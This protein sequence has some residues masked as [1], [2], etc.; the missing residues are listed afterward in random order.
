MTAKK[1]GIFSLPVIVAALGYFVD[2][3]DLLLFTIV[4]EPSLAG[5]GVQLSDSVQ[6]IAAS[7]KII[8]WQM[9]GLLIG[10]VLWGTIGDKK[11]RLSVL[12]GSIALYSVANF[13]TGFVQTVDQ[14]AW[15]RFIAGIGLAGELGAGITLVSELLPKEKRGVGTSLVAGIGLFGAVF[16]Y[17]VYK[18]T[19]DWRLC[20]MIG[21]GLGIGLLL[22]RISVTESGMFHS[23]KEQVGIQKGNFFM[24]FNNKKR[25]KK[26]LLAILIGL[27]TWYVIGILV[28]LSNRFAGALYGEN[29]I[30]S[31][32][33][34]MFAYVGIAIGDILIGLVS[35]YFKS[36]KKALLSFYLLCM[37]CL[38]F[39]YSSYNNSDAS[40][41]LICGLL[42]FST[43]FWAIFITMGA[44]QFGTN[45][46]ATAATTI[47]N[48]VR[49]ALPL[50]NLMFLN[51][52]QQTWGW[53]L[54]QS[55]IITGLIIMFITLVAFYFTEETFHKDLDFV[56]K[57]N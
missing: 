23:L 20:Y 26:Y 45:L 11:G 2:I 7:T 41:Y 34:I 14:Y 40:M 12:F 17:F 3:Y 27:P 22:L 44:E 54:I 32:R 36:R 56:E 1:Y 50:I 6:V 10:G 48:M 8:N 47:P 21:G 31:G 18:L 5:I 24:F 46:R 33:A 37:A 15:A 13:A 19:N 55:G 16:A 43:G 28:N 30:E 57:H 49:G 29:K 52:F 4:R 39:F 35:Q 9:V 25:F 38:V 51:L 53:S 42:G